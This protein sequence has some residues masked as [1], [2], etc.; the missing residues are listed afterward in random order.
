MALDLLGPT[1]VVDLLDDEGSAGP[2][3]RRPPAAG[4]RGAP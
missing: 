2:R 4:D 3:L 1:T